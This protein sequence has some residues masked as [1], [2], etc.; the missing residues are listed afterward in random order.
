VSTDDITINDDPKPE[1]TTPRQRRQRAMAALAEH[2]AFWK[3]RQAELA[4]VAAVYE[5]RWWQWVIGEAKG[6]VSEEIKSISNRYE[7][8][9]I[10]P[11]AS[12]YYANLFPRSMRVDVSP[13]A[14]TTGDPDKAGL[15]VNDW[16]FAAEQRQRWDSAVRQ[17]LLYPGVCFRFAVNHEDCAKPPPDRVELYV[18]PIWEAVIDREVYD[19][20]HQRFRGHVGWRPL[21]QVAAEYNLP[22]D[23]LAGQYRNDFL[24]SRGSSR[25]T[26][27]SPGAQDSTSTSLVGTEA[28]W[29]RVMELCNFAEDYVDDDGEVYRGSYEVYLLDQPAELAGKDEPLYVG[30][31]PGLDA[32]GEPAPHIF[33][34]F[35]ETRAEYPLQGLAPAAQ[36]MPQQRELNAYRSQMAD[37]A[38]R[39]KVIWVGAPGMSS[40]EKKKVVS[41]KDMEVLFPDQKT[42]K[43][44]GSDAR[45]YIAQVQPAK[46]SVDIERFADIAERDFVAEVALSPSAFGVR[47][48]VTAEEIQYQRDFTDSEFGRYASAWERTLEQLAE[49][50]VQ[51]LVAAMRPTP[52]GEWAEGEDDGDEDSVD[53]QPDYTRERDKDEDEDPM[54]RAAPTDEMMARM[55]KGS[56]PPRGKAA[57][58]SITLFDTTGNKVEVTVKD[59]DSWFK[60]SFSDV[61]RTP[62][63]RLE[64]RA[65]LSEVLPK[66]MELWVMATKD[67]GSPEA[68]IAREAMQAIYDNFTLP[69][70]LSPDRLWA[71]LDAAKAAKTTKPSPIDR[72]AEPAPTDAPPPAAPGPVE[73]PTQ[74]PAEDPGVMAEAALGEIEAQF[75]EDPTVKAE[76]ARIRTLPPEQQP[77]AVRALIASIQQVLTQGAA[78]PAPTPEA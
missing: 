59:L 9:K 7:T 33:V 46:A 26:A 48:N 29:V 30:P 56:K 6:E 52:D 28:K 62:G 65:N 72:A 44:I 78:Q 54:M 11:A 2:D 8:N 20:R 66:Y 38:S 4:G 12:A 75:G 58:Q 67:P 32:D 23:K 43:E 73:Q 76:V 49:A 61:G 70:N 1:P 53:I 19:V 37:K 18:C 27:Q 57:S 36:W 15:V 64:I 31:M 13:S 14:T 50:Y 10:K 22:K 3:E 71:A 74:A 17:A 68:I 16:M 34:H 69:P 60:F 51:T 41:A 40:D 24:D 42:W 21:E 77:D 63:A 25:G 47:Q 55:P 5:T 39:D 35:F 45:R